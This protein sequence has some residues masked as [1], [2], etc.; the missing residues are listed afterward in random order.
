MVYG[1]GMKIGARLLLRGKLRQ[2]LPYLIRPVNYWRAVEYKLVLAEGDFRSSD[3][4]LDIGSPKLLSLYLAKTVGAEVFATDVDDYFVA[5]YTYVQSMEGISRDRLHVEVEDGR[6]LHF[7]SNSFDKIYSISV[8]EHI[9]EQGDTECIKEIARI[10]APGGRCLVTVPFAPHS[11]VEHLDGKGVYWASHSIRSSA[12][13]V[14]Y[15]RRYS[16][17]DLFERLIEPS[18]LALRKLKY[19]GENVLTNSERELSDY[20]PVFSGPIQPLISRLFHSPPMD[21]WR[22]IKKPLCALVVLEK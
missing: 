5:R 10:L 17:A 15:Q 9:P 2:S 3:R 6:K 12:G 4:I 16:E 8:L 19:V 18:G 21:S 14:F 11:R 20:L 1:Y 13:K 22:D 7:D